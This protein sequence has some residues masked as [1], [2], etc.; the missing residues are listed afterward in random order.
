MASPADD[1][2]DRSAPAR[3]W[4]RSHRW[5]ALRRTTQLA[6][7]ALFLLGPLFGLWVVKGNLASSVTLDALPLTDPLVLLQSLAAGHRP[8]GQALLGAAFVTLFYLLAGGRVYCSWVCPLNAVTD[9]AAWLRERLGIRGGM[10]PSANLRYGLL[11]AALIAAAMTGAIAWELVNPVSVVFRGLVFGMGLAWAV[12]A[13]VF[14]LDLLLGKRL[15]CGHLCPVGAF[16][17]LIGRVSIVRVSASR[18]ERCDD[19]MDCYAVCPEPRVIGPA[20]KGASKGLGPVIFAGEC[21]NCCRCIDVCSQGVFRLS[22]RFH[23]VAASAETA[24]KREAMS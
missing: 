6:I 2:I 4:W 8:A 9:A 11:A 12:V 17:G 18:R 7:L 19:C 1:L 15:W 10:A 13:A 5:L 14:L 23:N 22:T 16:Y 21:T 20:L 3:G 24:G